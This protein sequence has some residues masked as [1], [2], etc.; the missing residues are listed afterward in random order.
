MNS[1][2]AGYQMAG[3]Q[4]SQGI[5]PA[6]IAQ[7]ELTPPTQ[8]NPE[9]PQEEESNVDPVAQNENMVSKFSEEQLRELSVQ[10]KRGFEI[11]CNSRGMWETQLE[12]W[13]AL[14]NQAR[15]NKSWPWANASNIKYPLIATA[16][17]Q[18]AARAYPSLVPS[19]GK[20][21]KSQ[22]VGKDRDGSKYDRAER[23]STY[24]SYQIFHEMDD[25]E[26]DMDR[27]LMMLAVSGT[28]FKKTWYDKSMDLIRSKVIL[29]KNLVVNYWTK[30]LN[31]CERISEVIMMSPRILEEKQ[32]QKVFT[33]IDLGPAPIPDNTPSDAAQ[34]DTIPYCLVEQHT[35]FDRDGDGYQEPYIVTFHKETGKILRIG[36]RYYLDDVEMD[37]TKIVKIKPIQMYTKFGFVPNP[38]GS[39]YDIAFGVLLGPLN[40]S[41]NT[42]VNQLVDAGTLNNLQSGFIGKGLKLRA[43]DT[44]MKP[45]EWKPV[46]VGGDDLRK[47]IVPLPAKE[48]STVLLTLMGSLIT[49]G[50]ELASVAEIFVGKMPGQNT[51]A[52]TTMASIEQGMKVF[53]AVYKRL[54][55]SLQQE[56]AKIFD[57]NKIYMDPNHYVKVIED[58]VGPEDFNRGDCDIFPGADPTA[59]SQTEKLLKAQGLIE[60]LPM[61]PGMLD[62]V[63]VF[64]RVLEAQ[65]QPNWQKLFSQEIQESGQL[66]PPPPDPKVMAIQAKAEADQR[67][68]AADIQMKQQS[69]ELDG[70]DK[71]MQMQMKQAEHAQ[72]M[73]QQQESATIKGASDIAMARIFTAQAAAKGNQELQNKQQKHTQDMQLSKE[74]AKSQSRTQTSKNG[75]AAK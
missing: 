28:M 54:Y 11:D 24:M 17:M 37:G 3:D 71:M 59:V 48:P 36:L 16:A 68:S 56:F 31:E 12:Q 40:E 50:K 39:F 4:A 29:P 41:V 53:T 5:D 49:S 62:P 30:S 60:L 22:V 35:F 42:I 7:Q 34:D 2:P 14:A 32:R 19:N 65:E 46:P 33:D 51:P 27:L 45:G 67:K 21:V 57:L 58:T 55:R 15:D 70:R 43:G 23:V 1:N 9:V 25:W 20:I 26:E 10:C 64:S 72:K 47:Q 6:M 44:I 18:F 69:M 38:D 52:T 75:K 61:V 66:P 73:Q 13:Q 8:E 63:E 74:K